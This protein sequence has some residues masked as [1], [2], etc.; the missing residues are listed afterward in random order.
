MAYYRQYWDREG[1]R[2]GR[3]REDRE[4]GREYWDREGYREEGYRDTSTGTQRQGSR[5]RR[6]VSSLRLLLPPQGKGAL[7]SVSTP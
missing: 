4:E 3:D 1:D 2:E 7:P 6:A 5:R